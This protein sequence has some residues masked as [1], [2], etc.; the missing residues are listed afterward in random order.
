M[1]RVIVRYACILALVL[2]GSA[3][4]PRNPF[5]AAASAG[6]APQTDVVRATIVRS[7]GNA[8]ASPDDTLEVE[9]NNVAIR[10]DRSSRTRKAFMTSIGSDAVFAALATTGVVRL[11]DLRGERFKDTS[12][13]T[14][15][16]ER[17]AAPAV[18]IGAMSYRQLP[19]AAAAAYLILEGAV[20]DATWE[21]D[22]YA[23]SM[24]PLHC[25]A[26]HR[27]PEPPGRP[28]QLHRTQPRPG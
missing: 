2:A 10:E 5:V 20:S 12:Y 22:P 19:P 26:I 18:A 14:V 13:V 8:P 15:T 24:C 9:P 25:H 3:C 23:L 6:I 16:I 27:G 7:R 11:G 28:P 17:R 4:A 21:P 1:G